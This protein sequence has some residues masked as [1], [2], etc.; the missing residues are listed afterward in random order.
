MPSA[1]HS[2]VRRRASS[3][4]TADT[5][6]A[7]SNHPI[8]HLRYAASRRHS[9]IAE[10]SADNRGSVARHLHPDVP[11][12]HGSGLPA[13]VM[14]AS[15]SSNCA[16]P[17]RQA[18][19]CVVTASRGEL[20]GASMRPA[21]ALSPA[22]PLLRPPT[23]ACS[24]R[25]GGPYPARTTRRAGQPGPAPTSTPPAASAARLHQQRRGNN[26][27]PRRPIPDLHRPPLCRA[28]AHRT[29]PTRDD[30][31]SE[32]TDHHAGRLAPTDAFIGPGHLRL[33]ASGP[34]RTGFVSPRPSPLTWT[35]NGMPS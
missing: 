13:A 10:Y 4:L 26:S 33:N 9:Q 8:R 20:A 24:A 11:V 16:P 2:P 6:S 14:N 29:P 5:Q 7:L 30:M 27:Q 18:P 28:R 19:G 21:P 35:T 17:H 1:L 31:H 3:V 12:L 23:T 25:R 32:I 22:R 34:S 15:A